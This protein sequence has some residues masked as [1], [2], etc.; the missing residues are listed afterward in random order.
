[1]VAG[2]TGPPSESLKFTLN[3][4]CTVQSMTVNN[5]NLQYCHNALSPSYSATTLTNPTVTKVPPDCAGVVINWNLVQPLSSDAPFDPNLIKNPGANVYKIDT[6]STSQFGQHTYSWI[7]T[8][9]TTDFIIGTTARSDF[10][11]FVQGCN[12]SSMSPSTA[13]PGTYNYMINGLN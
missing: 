6:T 7:G 3:L 8:A 5:P 10:N 4:I 13:G 12:S 1:M 9:Q 2:L 11:I